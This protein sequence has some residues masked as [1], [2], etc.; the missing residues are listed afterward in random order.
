MRL[1]ASVTLT[2]TLTARSTGRRCWRETHQR[3][4]RSAGKLQA[5]A[6]SMTTG[7]AVVDHD[8]SRI[9]DLK[10]R[11]CRARGV[12]DDTALERLPVVSSGRAHDRRATS[13][14]HPPQ[15]VNASRTPPASRRQDSTSPASVARQHTPKCLTGVLALAQPARGGFS[16]PSRGRTPAGRPQRG[17]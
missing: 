17:P 4:I 8:F 11:C 15:Q 13:E 14:R 6:L 5:V 16:S 2:S 7:T 1:R 9:V 3:T 12:R 10:E